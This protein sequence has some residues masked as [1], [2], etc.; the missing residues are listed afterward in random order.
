MKDEINRQR[1]TLPLL[2]DETIDF[3]DDKW[4]E[5][6]LPPIKYDSTTVKNTKV[7]E[8]GQPA[9]PPKGFFLNSVKKRRPMVEML[10]AVPLAMFAGYQ[11]KAMSV[12]TP[13]FGMF[14]TSAPTMQV[15]VLQPRMV[16]SAA[17]P[18]IQA[19]QFPVLAEKVADDPLQDAQNIQPA[20]NKLSV[21]EQVRNWEEPQNR[22]QPAAP[23]QHD[24][25]SM[26][27]VK[28]E[29]QM[30]LWTDSG[31]VVPMP[32]HQRAKVMADKRHLTEPVPLPRKRQMVKQSQ[33]QKMATPAPVFRDVPIA[34]TKSPADNGVKIAT[35]GTIPNVAPRKRSLFV[36]SYQP[37]KPAV[38]QVAKASSGGN[39][40]FVLF[41]GSFGKTKANSLSSIAA[42]LQQHSIA[43]IQQKVSL[44]TGSYT[45]L[46]AG[47]FADRDAAIAA[48][49][50]LLA[51]SKINSTVT[52]L[53]TGTGKFSSIKQEA[54]THQQASTPQE[55]ANKAAP[56]KPQHSS[57]AWNKYVVHV[58]SFLN[59]EDD[60]SGELLKKIIGIGGAGFQKDAKIKGKTF[61]RVY[62][63]PFQNVQQ[64]TM[65]KR[66][67]QEQLKLKDLTLMEKS[68]QEGWVKLSPEKRS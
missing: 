32:M 59:V 11:F 41:L 24:T 19:P 42:K 48:R 27:V 55:A 61:W 64:A 53:Q 62:S 13:G 34:A 8:E 26:A 36:K 5:E 43:T 35:S 17:A 39:E 7:E 28:H 47:P 56:S 51:N 66:I 40:G 65:A 23:E 10:V 49:N 67:L 9:K 4:Q 57:Q 14:A 52:Y 3:F 44:K 16:V 68:Q 2:D 63:G 45:R 22:V 37:I 30:N 6:L 21:R 58:G 54:S 50:N 38:Q 33:S 25:Q 31:M 15:E 29:G 1:D 46:Y 20:E 18:V 12:D 60:A